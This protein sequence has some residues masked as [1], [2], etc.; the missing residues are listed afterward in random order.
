MKIISGNFGSLGTASFDDN[1]WIAVF[2]DKAAAYPPSQIQ[3]AKA[4]REEETKISVLS[5]VL[6]IFTTAFL[7]LMFGILGFI[8]GLLLLLI[9]SKKHT[10]KHFVEVSFQDGN[11]FKAEASRKD[12]KRFFDFK[13]A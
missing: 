4:W 6:G 2:G 7:A 5:V 9:G 12:M 1:G 13:T 8:S 10:T 11:S 3:D